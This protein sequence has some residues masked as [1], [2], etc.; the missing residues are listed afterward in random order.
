[1][2]APAN[3]GDA[4]FQIQAAADGQVPVDR[5]AAAGVDGAADGQALPDRQTAVDPQVAG[6]LRV[7]VGTHEDGAVVAVE[8][9]CTPGTLECEGQDGAFVWCDTP[10]DGVAVEDFPLEAGDHW[11]V[12]QGLPGVAPEI[13]L[14]Y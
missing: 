5:Q 2:V 3:H 11:L 6:G 13:L 10:Q 9:V 8:P 12:V 14:N 1:V 4:A 7:L